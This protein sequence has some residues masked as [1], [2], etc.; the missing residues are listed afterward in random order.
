MTV[1]KIEAYQCSDGDIYT[2]EHQAVDHEI[3]LVLGK[4][5]DAGQSRHVIDVEADATDV[6]IG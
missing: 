1:K 2:E 5:I 6:K 4:A 3:E